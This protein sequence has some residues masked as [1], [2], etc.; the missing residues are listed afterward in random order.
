MDIKQSIT[1]FAHRPVMLDECVEA[2]QIRPHGIYVDC[3][4][5]GGG[6]SFEIAGRLEKDGRLIGIDQDTA[7]LTAAADRLC[8]YRDRITLVH[9][10]FQNI[11]AILAEN[12]IAGI[13]GALID[14]GVS[15]YQLDTPSR[16]FSYQHDAPL[17]MRMNTEAS[18]TAY[19][20]VNKYSR[21]ELC[22]I[23]REYGEERFASSIASH[24][25]K[26]R[27]KAPVRTTLELADIVRA[28]IPPANRADGPHPAKRTF[29]AIR[30]EVNQ[31]LSV[32]PPTLN[33]LIKALRPGGRLAVI[34]FHSLED[35]IVKQAFAAAAKGCTCP[36]EFPVCVCG[37]CPEI[38]VV[39]KKPITASA[40]EL[41][42]NPRARSAKLRVAEK[43]QAVGKKQ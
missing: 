43:L 2:L 37:K 39:N 19:D 1:S 22:R 36:P 18:L 3:T 21:N 35:R 7:A 4:L 24:I 8:V 30:I 5:G 33:T 41:A 29:Q 32:I 6:H 10:N 13:D 17:D 27:E 23:I 34:S 15:S 38:L 12:Q 11:R 42:E 20:I 14:L 40:A 25:I 16:G 31:E 9:D 28:S 26:A